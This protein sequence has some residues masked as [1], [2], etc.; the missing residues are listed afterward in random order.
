M[1]E[2]ND[3]LTQRARVWLLAA[4]AALSFLAYWVLVSLALGAKGSLVYDTKAAV[5]RGPL[6]WPSGWL[7]LVSISETGRMILYILLMVALT[8]LWL[9]AM[10]LVRRD[11]RR[12]LAYIVFVAFALFAAL[13]VFGPAFQSRDIFSYAFHG[14]AMTVYHSNPYLL[15]P[16]ARPHDVFYP[17]IGWR[18]NASVYGPVFNFVSY[19]IARAGGGS[20]ASNVLGFKILAFL[21]YLACLPMVYT[22]ARRVSP[23]RE[24]LA[25]AMTAWCPILVMHLLGAGHA[26]AFMIALVLA[27]YLLY[28]KGYPLSGIAVVLVAAMI[29]V[30]AAIALAPMLVLYVRDRSGVPL[31]RLASAAALVVA[32]PVLLYLPFFQGLRIFDTTRHM[33][34]L[35]SNTS[36]QRVFGYSVERILGFAWVS[37]AQ[38]ADIAAREAH[39]LFLAILAIIAIALFLRVKDFR[40]MVGCAAALSLVWVLTSGY[41]LPWYLAMGIMLGA[42]TGWNVTTASLVGAASI[43]TMYRIPGLPTGA[44]PEPIFWLGGPMLIL[45]AGWLILTFV[46]ALGRV[47]ASEP[48]GVVDGSGALDEG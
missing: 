5:Y 38:A 27:G 26:D 45:L 25:L 4:L 39:Y 44:T 31:K 41:A 23:G 37:S 18:Y 32:I 30:T 8:V 40:T 1:S 9:V 34:G 21:S 15:I 47:T 13:F 35:T 24:N 10:Y 3:R 2:G 17:F 7:R 20:I 11:R 33:F 28:R 19:V 14:R 46:P 29:K 16:H 36:S 12:V 22:L 48:V 42:V 6:T 43:F